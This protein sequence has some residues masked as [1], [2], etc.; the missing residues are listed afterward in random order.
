M[1]LGILIDTFFVDIQQ[2][3]RALQLRQRQRE[4]PPERVPGSSPRR[5][6][7]FIPLILCPLDS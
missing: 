1:K 6:K 2:L 5:N 3:E 4:P 7:H